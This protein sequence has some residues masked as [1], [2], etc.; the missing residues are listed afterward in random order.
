[1]ATASFA[2]VL[3]VSYRP[4][5]VAR[6]NPALPPLLELSLSQT[7][8]QGVYVYRLD[9][10]TEALTLIAAS[11]RPVSDIDT[12]DVE[13]R[14]QAAHWHRENQTAVLLDRDAWTDWRLER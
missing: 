7:N 3:S 12:Y 14:P 10:E 9:R 8:S 6:G 4:Q 2:P 1:M 13:L 5:P 11:G